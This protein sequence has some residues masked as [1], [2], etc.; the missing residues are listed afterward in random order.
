MI[1]A[2][3]ILRALWYALL[4]PRGAWQS[5]STGAREG[6]RMGRAGW[7]L[8][9]QISQNGTPEI[10]ARRRALTMRK[11]PDGGWRHTDFDA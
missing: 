10:E 2:R 3:L 5:L 4:D 1:W 7:R 6:Y 8:S 11:G 9:L